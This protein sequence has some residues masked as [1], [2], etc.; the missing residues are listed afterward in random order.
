MRQAGQVYFAKISQGGGQDF[1]ANLTGKIR[2]NAA[3]ST[4]G[5]GHLTAPAPSSFSTFRCVT[6]MVSRLNRPDL[7]RHDNQRIN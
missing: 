5:F 4:L 2:R 3:S 6:P 7:N 1:S